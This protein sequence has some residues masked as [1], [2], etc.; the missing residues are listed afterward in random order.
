MKE[1]RKTVRCLTRTTGIMKL[2]LTQKCKAMRVDYVCGER[3]VQFE[4]GKFEIPTWHQSGAVKKVI[5]YMSL[6]FMRS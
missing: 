3:S 2:P 5:G 4:N 1:S 6:E